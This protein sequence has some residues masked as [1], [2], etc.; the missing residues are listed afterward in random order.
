VGEARQL[1]VVAMR[2]Q[3]MDTEGTWSSRALQ[4]GDLARPKC[5]SWQRRWHVGKKCPCSAK[6]KLTQEKGTGILQWESW[7]SVVLILGLWSEGIWGTK[8]WAD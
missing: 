5:H 2:G 4:E 1:T 7:N 8:K 3:L 6:R